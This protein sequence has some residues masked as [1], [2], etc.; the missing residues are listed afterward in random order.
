MLVVTLALMGASGFLLYRSFHQ[1]PVTFQASGAV[2]PTD[3][4]I[5]DKVQSIS[6]RMHKA[7]SQFDPG[8]A[9][10]QLVVNQQFQQLSTDALV[11]V[12]VGSYGRG[13]PFIA[14]SK[15]P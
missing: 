4:S 14:P 7:I 12:A 13:N 11:N 3:T 2:T 9:L 5:R 10:D 15:N 6:V 8:G 1:E